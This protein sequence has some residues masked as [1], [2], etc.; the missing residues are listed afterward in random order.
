[1]MIP[2]IVGSVSYAAGNNV[3]ERA[4]S[5]LRQ[6][7]LK[8]NPMTDYEGAWIANIETDVYR[9]GTFENLTVGYSANNGWDFGISLLNTQV[10]GSHNNFQGNIF[11][12]IAKTFDINKDL[13]ITLGTQNGVA[14][15]NAQ[16]QQ[17]FN[18]TFLDNSYDITSWLTLHG[19]PYVANAAI[20]GTSRQVGFLTGIGMIL[21]PNKL[22]LQMDY[23]SGHHA[24]SGANVN[25][26][27]NLTPRCQIYMGVLVPEQNSGN[28][29]AGILGFNLSTHNL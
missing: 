7:R 4:K 6:K 12:N 10:L 25:M 13:A 20:T 14:L 19:G 11:A 22:A 3:K 27:C 28:E 18:F 24:L 23:V 26:V 21:S 29:F 16:P 1:M 8:I 17:W 15:V 2:F 5:K 9:D